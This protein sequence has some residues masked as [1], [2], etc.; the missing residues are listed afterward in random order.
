MIPAT[1]NATNISALFD[2]KLATPLK[3]FV[4]ADTMLVTTDVKALATLE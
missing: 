1:A 4:I 2:M 3:K